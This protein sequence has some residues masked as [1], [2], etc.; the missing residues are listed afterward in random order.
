M[1]NWIPPQQSSVGKS[2]GSEPWWEILF[3]KRENQEQEAM[4]DYNL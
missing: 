3:V 2:I 4:S 1:N